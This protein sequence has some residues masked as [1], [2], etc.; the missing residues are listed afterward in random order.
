MPCV[1]LN[2]PISIAIEE[3]DSVGLALVATDRK[4]GNGVE[5]FTAN[6]VS[7]A[8]SRANALVD[9]GELEDSSAVELTWRRAQKRR[10]SRRY[11][12]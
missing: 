4:T 7:R 12:S 3:V 1:R 5:D 9:S 8:A 11:N 2:R 10:T 6:P